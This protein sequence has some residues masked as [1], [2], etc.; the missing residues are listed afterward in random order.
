M[1]IF[2]MAWIITVTKVWRR[3]ETKFRAN[4]YSPIQLANVQFA[5]IVYICNE[6]TIP[7]TINIKL[8]P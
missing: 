5:K 2:F 7:F 6:I 8:K 3:C 4:Y 1:R